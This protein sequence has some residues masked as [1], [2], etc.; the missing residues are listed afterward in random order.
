MANKDEKVKKKKTFV[1]DFKAELKKVTWP[2]PKQLVNN[3]VG[4]IFITLIVAVIVFVLDLTFDSVNKYGING[5]KGIVESSNSVSTEDVAESDEDGATEGNSDD[6]ELSEDVEN[7]EVV[8]NEVSAEETENT[9]N[10]EAET[11]VE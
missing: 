2:T 1:K 5:L 11:T 4:V 9:V 3:T 10:N 6:L 8:N 7:A